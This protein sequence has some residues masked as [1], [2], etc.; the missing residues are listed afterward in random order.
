[1]KRIISLVALIFLCASC[2]P[3][4][5]KPWKP[6][7]L[8]FKMT[9]SYSVQEGLGAIKKPE[10]PKRIFVKVEGDKIS[11]VPKEEA[12]HIMFAPEEYAKIGAVV[13]IAAAY[14]DIILEQEKLVNIYITEINALKELVALEQKKSMAYRELWI[15]S[16]NA[17]R[18][19]VHDHK[20][21]NILNRGFVYVVTVGSILVFLLAL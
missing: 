17:Y 19:E 13:K 3:T 7:E 18:Q 20:F 9:P 16:E 5:L 8:I 6:P 15:S 12:T 1:M 14:K 11:V 2:G 21:D 4:V 10:P